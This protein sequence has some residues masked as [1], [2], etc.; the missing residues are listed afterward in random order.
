MNEKSVDDMEF[1]EL[2]YLLHEEE[3]LTLDQIGEIVGCSAPCARR[4][5][6]AYRIANPDLPTQF[7]DHRNTNGK[8][9]DY[10]RMRTICSMRASGMTLEAIASSYG[11]TRERVRQI[12]ARAQAIEPELG[13]QAVE[14]NKQLRAMA[15]KAKQP[16]IKKFKQTVFRWLAEYGLQYCSGCKCVKSRDDD[17]SPAARKY[18][19]GGAARAQEAAT[20]YVVQSLCK[21]CN[22]DRA[23]RAWRTNPKVREYRKKYVKENPAVGKRACKRYYEKLKQDPEKWNKFLDGQRRKANLRNLMIKVMQPERYRM[24]R[25][26]ENDR[27]RRRYAQERLNASAQN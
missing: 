7:T 1:G 18:L 5:I 2:E 24:L 4:R 25:D 22:A 20:V 14:G 3:K 13:K 8:P 6:E 26:K 27:S 19:I 21:R 12:L 9:R 11:L 16:L 23:N 10:D 15:K 17:F